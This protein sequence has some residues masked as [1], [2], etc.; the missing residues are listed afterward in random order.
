[1]KPALAEKN[2]DSYNEAKNVSYLPWQGSV[3]KRQ[4]AYFL[5]R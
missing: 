1:M 4:S 3:N 2:F 5:P